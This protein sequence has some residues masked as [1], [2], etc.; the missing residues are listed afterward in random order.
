[1]TLMGALAVAV[2]ALT[3]ASLLI[4][5]ALAPSPA[6]AAPHDEK[7][8]ADFMWMLVDECG[9]TEWR[10]SNREFTL[11]QDDD[12][13]LRIES[14]NLRGVVVDDPATELATMERINACLARY[15]MQSLQEA[16]ALW[17]PRSSA[18]R[19][20][21]FDIYTHRVAPCLA[22]LG[23]TAPKPDFAAYLQPDRSPWGEIYHHITYL[24]DG[25]IRPFAEVLDARRA[26]GT[27]SDFLAAD[28][29]G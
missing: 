22:A 13:V 10:L 4:V 19:V 3:V 7:V 9:G 17:R 16:S 14:V 1:M 2:T 12:D 29:V 27:P 20:V 21:L 18:E 15:S 26:C 5:N 11:A 23:L 28:G 6:R 24:P 25:T 8:P